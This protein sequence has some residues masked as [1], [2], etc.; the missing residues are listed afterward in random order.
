MDPREFISVDCPKY[1]KNNESL[2]STDDHTGRTKHS[3][4]YIILSGHYCMTETKEFSNYLNSTGFQTVS[5][6]SRSLKGVHGV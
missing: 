6:V 1:L 2:K 4:S 3:F 5:W